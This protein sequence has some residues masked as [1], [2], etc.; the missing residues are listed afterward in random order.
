MVT[1][2][3]GV[4]SG[5]SSL[6]EE[7]AAMKTKLT[8]PLRTPKKHVDCRSGKYQT[9]PRRSRVRQRER[10]GGKMDVVDFVQDT[11]ESFQ[12]LRQRW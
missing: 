9:K 3:A 10:L 4:S 2:G 6:F 7:D 5:F 1:V 11:W 8:A 12:V